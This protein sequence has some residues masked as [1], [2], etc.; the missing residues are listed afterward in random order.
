MSKIQQYN[1][2]LNQIEREIELIQR[3]AAG[4]E[5]TGQNTRSQKADQV[6]NIRVD[7]AQ[8]Q[9][10]G[11]E[12]ICGGCQAESLLRQMIF[13]LNPSMVNIPPATRSYPNR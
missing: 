11:D 7:L 3:A 13:Q 10:M 1:H 8:L 2:R 5:Y 6:H 4:W 12:A 9:L